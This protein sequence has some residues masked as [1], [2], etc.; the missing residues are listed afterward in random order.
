FLFRADIPVQRAE[1]V[2]E[3]RPLRQQR[4]V[5]KENKEVAHSALSPTGGVQHAAQAAN[6]SSL[7]PQEK[8]EPVK[9]KKMAGRNDRVSVKYLDGSIKKDVK[10][11][12]VEEDVLNNKCVIIDE[13]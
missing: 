8:Q 2:R 5:Y 1:D 3:A 4:P 10:F 11:K 7:P 9:V 13:D 12:T 6:A